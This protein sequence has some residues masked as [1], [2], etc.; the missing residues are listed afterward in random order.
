MTN[1]NYELTEHGRKRA[2][3]RAISDIVLD[4]LLEY[5]E[6]EEQKGGTSLVEFDRRQ[7]KALIRSLKQLLRALTNDAPPFAVMGERGGVITV[8]HKYKQQH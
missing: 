5:G 4:V 1:V 3:Q 8:G 2:A 6:M 7:R